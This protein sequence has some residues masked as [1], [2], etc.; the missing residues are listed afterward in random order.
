MVWLKTIV[1]RRR[2]RDANS[3]FLRMACGAKATWVWR[4]RK[5]DWQFISVCW[6][7]FVWANVAVRTMGR[8]LTFG[9]KFVLSVCAYPSGWCD[10]PNVFA[11]RGSTCVPISRVRARWKVRRWNQRTACYEI[12]NRP[13]I[14]YAQARDT[15]NDRKPTDKDT[16]MTA[17]LSRPTQSPIQSRNKTLPLA[18]SSIC[19]TTV[20]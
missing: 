17:A 7:F 4:A 16:E 12:I 8:R 3:D 2:T 5:A 18:P 14:F 9:C 13:P 1:P 10:R 11:F 6:V 19:F 20:R 15:A